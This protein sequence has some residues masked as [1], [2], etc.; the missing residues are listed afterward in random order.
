MT[1][2]TVTALGYVDGHTSIIFLDRYRSSTVFSRVF[3]TVD[4]QFCFAFFSYRHP[5]GI[6]SYP[7]APICLDENIL[8]AT[9][10]TKFEGCLGSLYSGSISIL[11]Y[12]YL[13]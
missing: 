1:I 12:N 10:T 11:P 6:F 3:G 2:V 9:I 7:I 8:I 13:C 5:V 4:A